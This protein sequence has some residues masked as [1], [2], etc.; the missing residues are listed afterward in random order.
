[1]LWPAVG[2]KTT[3]NEPKLKTI[4][5][6]PACT[7]V[8]LVFILS[9]EFRFLSTPL[10]RVEPLLGY[11]KVLTASDEHNPWHRGQDGHSGTIELPQLLFTGSPRMGLPTEAEHWVCTASCAGTGTFCSRKKAL[12]PLFNFVAHFADMSENLFLE[13]FINV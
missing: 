8:H 13:K 5:H 6:H 2:H 10:L 3:L 7:S 4:W 1:M 12:P 9:L 11:G